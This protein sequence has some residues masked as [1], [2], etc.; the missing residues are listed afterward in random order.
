MTI[1]KFQILMACL[2]AITSPA[3]N[4]VPN[5]GFEEV[6]NIYCSG[7]ASGKQFE[8]A[9]KKWFLPTSATPKLYDMD[10]RPRCSGYISKNDFIQP[11]SGRKLMAL[12]FRSSGSDYRSYLE[13][14]LVKELI[15]GKKYYTEIWVHLPVTQGKACNNIGLYFSE[16][17]IRVEFKDELPLVNLPFMGVLS[18]TPQVNHTAIVSDTSG[19]V[20]LK[21][22]FTAKTKANYLVIGNFFSDKNTSTQN[23]RKDA[24]KENG[25]FYR[26]DDIYVGLTPKE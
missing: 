8:A 5:S 17:P 4:L 14:R 20:C 2:I 15:V 18:L 26:I 23:T 25:V 19:W 13:V 10:A 11:H 16:V 7:F 9:V 6:N 1:V 22:T 24:P 3:Q 21:A 12:C